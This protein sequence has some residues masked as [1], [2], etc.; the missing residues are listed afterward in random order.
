M[1]KQLLSSR[2]DTGYT[3]FS[4]MRKSGVF[5]VGFTYR[6]RVEKRP[7]KTDGAFQNLPLQWNGEEQLAI[8]ELDGVI[9]FCAV[10]VQG[11]T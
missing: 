10:K 8:R 3:S 6:E 11:S 4:E 7:A 5:A 1:L 2:P 9:R